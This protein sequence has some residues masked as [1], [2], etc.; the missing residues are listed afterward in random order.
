L[1][2][3]W[4]FGF[5]EKNLMKFTKNAKRTLKSSEFANLSFKTI[6]KMHKSLNKICN[7]V[8]KIFV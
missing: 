4:S 6:A 1:G 7:S 2:R 8:G 5:L 3:K